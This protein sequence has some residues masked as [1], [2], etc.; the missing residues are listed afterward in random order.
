MGAPAF[1]DNI[2]D[3]LLDKVEIAEQPET[4]IEN[5]AVVLVDGVTH[6]VDQG[7]P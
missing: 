3:E 2:P 6:G 7:A 5:E 1:P 4:D